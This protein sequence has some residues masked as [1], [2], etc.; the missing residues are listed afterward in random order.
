MKR[1]RWQATLEALATAAETGGM[2]AVKGKLGGADALQRADP[3][4]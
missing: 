2:D 3:Q 4:I 1:A